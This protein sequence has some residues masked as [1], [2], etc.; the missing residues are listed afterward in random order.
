[1]SKYSRKPVANSQKRKL[2]VSLTVR[3]HQ[4]V[5]LLELVHAQ[6]DPTVGG[7]GGEEKNRTRNLHKLAMSVPLYK[8]QGGFLI[9]TV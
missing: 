1:M 7:R 2:C 3:K 6:K 9:N 5:L 8:L 4:Y